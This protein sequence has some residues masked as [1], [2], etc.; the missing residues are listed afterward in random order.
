[1]KLIGLLLSLF[2]FNY[3]APQI[4]VNENLMIHYDT[5]YSNNYRFSNALNKNSI[6]KVNRENSKKCKRNCA[7]SKKCVGIYENYDNDY[8]CNLLSKLDTK[9]EPVNETSNSIIK[10]SHHNYPL[11][12]HSLK[13]IIWDSYMFEEQKKTE[14]ITVYLDLNHN[15]ILDNDE[16]H[17]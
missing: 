16:H 10:I 14:N 6:I 17:Y 5:L 8:Y 3:G 11:G 9:A 15:G 4:I 2:C 12:N 1:M 7:F 13:G